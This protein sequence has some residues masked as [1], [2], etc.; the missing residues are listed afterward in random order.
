MTATVLLTLD[1]LNVWFDRFNDS[2]FGGALE[3][4]VFRITRAA[5]Y[6]GN[7]QGYRRKPPVIRLSVFYDRGEDALRTTLLHEMIHLWQFRTLGK[8]DHGASFKAKAADIYSRSGGEYAITRRTPVDGEVSARQASVSCDVLLWREGDA[9]CVARA[10]RGRT[11]V[12]LSLLRS[13]HPE[14]LAV[15]GEGALFVSMP[16][17]RRRIHYRRYS[18]KEFEE[19]VVM[20]LKEPLPPEIMPGVGRL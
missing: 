6:L 7:F 17:S 16:R 5:S 15:R 1:T 20:F 11:P 4:P 12:L 13:E 9:W 14:A 2:Y 10:D 8:P 19:K 18:P 3:R